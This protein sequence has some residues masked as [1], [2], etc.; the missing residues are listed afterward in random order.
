[1]IERVFHIVWLGAMTGWGDHN[2]IGWRHSHGDFGYEVVVHEDA[3]MLLPE[4]REYFEGASCIGDQAE[5]LQY[6]ILERC[7]G[8]MVH[9]DTMPIYPGCLTGLA[10]EHGDAC[11]LLTVGDGKH[12]DVWCMAASDRCNIWPILH[13]AIPEQSKSMTRCG[14]YSCKMLRGL[15]KM[16]PGTVRR[17]DLDGL[18]HHELRGGWK[19]PP[20]IGEGADDAETP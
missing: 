2:M 8:W 16:R 19:A 11:E 7:G 4:Y 14:R 1:M 9:L 15:E 12:P 13:K 5:L 10:A 6:S 18:I 20:H 17:M 3:S